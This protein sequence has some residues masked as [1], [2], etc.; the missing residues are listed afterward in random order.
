MPPWLVTA[1]PTRRRFSTE[2]ANGFN[3]APSPVLTRPPWL[4]PSRGLE[5]ESACQP[6]W[7]E[8]ASPPP[9]LSP[10]NSDVQFPDGIA[11]IVD[12]EDSGLVEGTLPPAK[13][14]ETCDSLYRGAV[15]RCAM[16]WHSHPIAKILSRMRP[17]S[18]L[19]VPQP[20]SCAAMPPRATR[21][22]QADDPSDRPACPDRSTVSYASCHLS[23]SVSMSISSTCSSMS[24][25]G[26]C[27]NNSD[28]DGSSSSHVSDSRSCCTGKLSQPP[29]EL[30]SERLPAPK[31]QSRPPR[32]LLWDE[33][34]P[35]PT[36]FAS[37]R[38]A[39]SSGSSSR[40]S[41]S[42]AEAGGDKLCCGSGDRSCRAMMD[43]GPAF[44]V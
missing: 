19:V 42:D 15:C 43:S 17:S 13:L 37:D 36:G 25:G 5:E 14:C 9:R 33:W 26:S 24:G 4:K 41:R 31:L 20:V 30:R 7:M 34:S 40:S 18:Q 39:A 6:P 8:Q 28:S 11:Y 3:R 1:A 23:S 32:P 10:R 29:P 22:D 38:S 12:T 21:E 44:R 2:D 27:Y 16:M 35:R